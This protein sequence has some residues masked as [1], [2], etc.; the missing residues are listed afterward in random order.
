MLPAPPPHGPPA[1][2]LRR[3]Q[4]GVPA[5]TVPAGRDCDAS[6]PLPSAIRSDPAACA[7]GTAR[8]PAATTLTPA[9]RP[10]VADWASGRRRWPALRDSPERAR[11][12]HIEPMPQDRSQ[13]RVPHALRQRGVEWPPRRASAGGCNLDM[14]LA[15]S[16]IADSACLPAREGGL[17]RRV[18]RGLGR[19]RMRRA[20]LGGLAV[21]TPSESRIDK[22]PRSAIRC[23]L[24]IP[25][26][27][28]SAVGP[29]PSDRSPDMSVPGA[30]GVVCPVK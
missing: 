26:C 16:A 25:H 12:S 14:P 29:R 28:L 22:T 4:R 5:A 9:C 2:P 23:M 21:P 19:R 10:A 1:C 17:C 3:T 15:K 27:L 8:R 13:L 24:R 30:R 18:G 6:L 7:Q 20:E 11:R